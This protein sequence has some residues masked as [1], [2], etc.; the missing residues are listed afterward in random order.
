MLLNLFT[1]AAFCNTI[2]LCVVSGVGIVELEIFR[3]KSWEELEV[4]VG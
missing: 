3:E 2:R 4:R 1:L